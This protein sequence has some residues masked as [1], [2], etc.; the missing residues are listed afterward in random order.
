[1][2]DRTTLEHQDRR[3]LSRFAIIACCLMWTIGSIADEP[4]SN[5]DAVTP[6][7]RVSCES[8]ANVV[9]IHPQVLSG[10]APE[11]TAGFRELVDMGVK[12]I[13][14]VDGAAPNV[15]V[16]RGLG[17]RYIHLPIGYGGISEDRVHGL[18]KVLNEVDDVIYIHCHH[19]KHRAAA[20]AAT[21]CFS[22]GRIS[23]EQA[24]E[25]LNVAGT[26][27]VYHGLFRAVEQAKRVSA[28]ELSKLDIPL[29][30]IAEVPAMAE[31]MADIGRTH[32]RIEA[33]A[34]ANW[35]APRD[36]PDLAPRHEVRLLR[37]QLSEL[38]RTHDMTSY[39][40]DF[41]KRLKDSARVA[42][43]LESVL[44]ESEGAT[45][46]ERRAKRATLVKRISQQC[47]DCHAKHRN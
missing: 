5:A 43:T 38:L 11:N 6:P 12:V 17:L 13:V 20:A 47:T 3:L 2:P 28:A 4:S 25:T 30:E 14:S 8:L 46:D 1:M 22:T 41:Q 19:G 16:A 37:Q 7:R 29:S 15:D 45:D 33:L 36:H 44:T 32:A 23:R 42:Q 34:R 9:Q 21:A 40:D 35:D 18:A 24:R 39:P 10:G 31:A 27:T 26:D